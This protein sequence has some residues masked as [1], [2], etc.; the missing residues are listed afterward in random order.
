MKIAILI[1]CY[2]EDENIKDLFDHLEKYKEK[3]NDE[4]VYIF[5]DDGSTDQTYQKI[6]SYNFNYLYHLPINQGLGNATRIGLEIAHYI[7]AD[8]CIKFDADLQHHSKDFDEI[9]NLFKKNS[10][11]IIYASRFNGKIHYKMPL[12]RFLGNKFFIWLMNLITNYKITDSQTGMMAFN[13]R[14]LSIFEMPGTY[15]PPQQALYDGYFKG[16]RY[17]ETT[18]D[19]FL[20]K[21]G[22]S[23]ISINYIYN[24]FSNL[25]KIY[26]K[27]S[28][29]KF[30]L[31]I[32]LVSFA[33]IL[34]IFYKFINKLIDSSKIYLD[35][36]TLF[37]SLIIIFFMSFY[38]GLNL[39]SSNKNKVFFRDRNKKNYL[40]FCTDFLEC[41]KK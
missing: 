34:V 37:L 31:T 25:F 30:Y 26:Y 13:R 17:A 20:R 33:S 16:L 12:Y 36:S 19:F 9:I 39:Y 41:K 11:D 29:Y 5:I 2:N 22:K 10:S 24:V 7:D 18:C 35:H 21:K 15:N 6:K 40:Y 32:S 8:V 4:I 38:Q 28:F 3:S 14:F 27:H 23:F 1:P